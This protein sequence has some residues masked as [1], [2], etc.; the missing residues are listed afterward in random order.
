MAGS[1]SFRFHIVARGRQR[2]Q[3]ITEKEQL[4]GIFSCLPF[5]AMAN[6]SQRILMVS[7]IGAAAALSPVL[8]DDY[9]LIFP[10]ALAFFHLAFA[11]ADNTALAAALSFFLDLGTGSVEA[12]SVA[13]TFSRPGGLPTCPVLRPGGFPTLRGCNGAP[14]S[15]SN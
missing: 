3:P 1:P 6:F 12:P 5:K 10:A 11:A 2:R 13:L 15:W 8:M 7:F 4:P 14:K 9:S